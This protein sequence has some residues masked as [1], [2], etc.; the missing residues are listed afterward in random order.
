M[1]AIQELLNINFSVFLFQ[2]FAILFGIKAVVSIFEWVLDKLGL[3]TKGMRKKRK[4]IY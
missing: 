3:E 2:F 1:D 4:E